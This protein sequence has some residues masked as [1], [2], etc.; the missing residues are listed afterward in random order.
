MTKGEYLDSVGVMVFMN[1]KTLQ[2]EADED[3]KR[4][5]DRLVDNFRSIYNENEDSEV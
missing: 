5:A 1:P 4:M 3:F 2:E